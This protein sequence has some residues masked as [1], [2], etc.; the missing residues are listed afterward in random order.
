MHI[1]TTE[2]KENIKLISTPLKGVLPID[3]SFLSR[4]TP[5][6]QRCANEHEV[7]CEAC[8]AFSLRLKQLEKRFADAVVK[9]RTLEQCQAELEKEIFIK[10]QD[11]NE[12]SIAAERLSL[13][14]KQLKSRLEDEIR[15]T[16]R[17]L[18][19]MKIEYEKKLL[20]LRQQQQQIKTTELHF[21]PEDEDL[22]SHLQKKIK[23]LTQDY[24]LEKNSKM[25]IIE[26]FEVLKQA[27]LQLEQLELE[28][29]RISDSSDGSVILEDD[30]DEGECI[31]VEDDILQG[32]MTLADEL[33]EWEQSPTVSRKPSLST[34]LKS[35]E[36]NNTIQQ[37]NQE[38]MK[39]Q[40]QLQSVTLQNEKLHS[41]IGFLLQ[42]QANSNIY[43][44]DFDYEYSDEIN[45]R[46]A[47][48]NLKKVLR[49]VSAAPINLNSERT[50]TKS[51]SCDQISGLFH[52][53]IRKRNLSPTDSEVNNSQIFDFDIALP[54]KTRRL[55][56]RKKSRLCRDLCSHSQNIICH[57]CQLRRLLSSITMGKLVLPHNLEIGQESADLDLDV[58]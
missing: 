44:E 16:E 56:K 51:P 36:L 15:Y 1:N 55:P 42:K 3:S 2:D 57:K 40:F 47:K 38:V 23:I 49:S 21:E 26:E 29:M 53:D 37:H 28:N 9:N 5:F 6:N 27:Y 31:S 24:E 19:E 30:F 50:V 20:C 7:H 33:N 52:N 14:N 54:K 48:R 43:K 11:L 46:N 12:K 22:V 45:I 17:C 13:E 32:G 34:Q 41:Y 39:L 10:E 8:D 25:V 58:D 4:P 18:G 35:L